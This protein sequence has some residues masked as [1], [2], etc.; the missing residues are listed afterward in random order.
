MSITRRRSLAGGFALVAVLALAIAGLSSGP[1]SAA[2][3][4]VYVVH[5]IPGTPVDVYAGGTLA[6]PMFQPGDVAGPLTL[7][8]GDLPILV[9]AAIA[10]PPEAA[11]DRSDSAVIDQVVPVPSGANVSLV[12]NIEGGTPNLQA[13]ANDL[14]AVPEGSARV[15]VRHTAD[16]PAVDILVNGAV[17]I[18]GLSPGTE[19]A[20]VLPAGNYD[21][22]VRLTDGTPVPALSPGTVDITAGRNVVVYA[23]GSASSEDVPLGLVQQV[24]EVPTQAA[25]TTTPTTAPA[26]A[27]APAAAASPSFTG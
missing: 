25:P 6:L 7:P 11:A 13:F 9:F 18:P 17:A 14:S 3:S 20:A 8:Q 24:L 5:G 21:I 2:D 16:A 15:T 12:A 27:P 22:Q 23:V 26:P 1:A 19:A 10:S 4:Q